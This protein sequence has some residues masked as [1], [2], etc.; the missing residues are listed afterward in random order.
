MSQYTKFPVNNSIQLYAS[1]AAFPASAANGALALA[2]DTDALYAYNTTLAAWVAIGGSGSVLSVGTI[3]SQAPSANGATININALIMQS[4]SGA[5]PGLVNLASQTFAGQKTFST[6]LTGTLTGSAS[7]NVLTSALG[8]L[9]DAGT[10]GIVVTG[11]TGSVVGSVSLAQHVADSTHNGYLSSTDWT[12]FNNKQSTLTLGN[13]TDAGTDGITVTGG[14]G[15]V[16]GAGTSLSQH[17]SDSTHNGYL[18]STDWTT[19]NNKQPAGSYITALTGDVT[20]TGPGSSAATVAKI[21]GTT[22]SGTTGTT[23][24]VF[25]ASPTLTGTITA[26]AANFSGAITAS[27]FSGSS[28]G[29]NT[30]DVTLTAFGS[31]PS[32]NGASLSGQA[33]TLQP[34]DATH[35][36]GVTTGSQTFAGTKTFTSTIAADIS[37][38]AA[39]ATSATTAT[40]ATNATNVATTATNATNASFFP[41]FV[42][43]SSSSNQGI[44]TATGLSFNP[45]TNTLTT[46]TFAG[47][48]TSA[49]T[50]TT[51]TTATNATNVATTSVSTNASFFPLFVA[52][53]TNSNQ[54][55]DLGTG[56]TFNP[57]TN[58][59]TTTT[60]TGALSGNA[61]TATTAT[62]ATNATN[63]ATT[64]VATNASF[65][66]LF[67]ASSS[68]GNQA[69]DLGTGLTF[70]PSTNTLSTTTFVGALTGT[71]SG[72]TTY[73]PNNHGVVLSSATNA[74]TVLAPNASTVFPLVSG[75]TG[76]DPSWAGLTVGGGGTGVTSN[77]AYAVLCGGTT[78][79]GAIQ[80]I[81]GVGT[82]GQV[83]TSNGAGALPTFQT[84]AALTNPMT[85]LGDIIYENAVP[86]PARLAGNTT[87]TKQ[88][89]SQ[90]GNGSI[91]ATPAWAQV[92]FA[93]ISGTVT[94][95]Q[96]GTG[97]SSAA[98]TGIAHV[99]AGTW[100]YSA[101]DLSGADATGTLAAGRFPALTGDITTSAGSLATTAAAT[102]ANI[103]TLSKSTGVAVHGTNTND[104]AAAGYVGEYVESKSSADNAYPA[105]ATWGDA[106]SI[107][108]TA[109][110]WDVSFMTGSIPSSSATFPWA[111][112]GISTTSGNSSTG[113][114]KGENL[115]FV[116]TNTISNT[117]Y[118]GCY[119]P[120]YRM[121]L[122]GT[123]T[124]YG[125]VEASWT[126][127]APSYA[128]RLS[129]RRVR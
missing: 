66:P 78:S 117:P 122:S 37:G 101:V 103:V 14:T 68:N 84:N 58:N 7:L 50:A 22:V 27:N 124:V 51:A 91:S 72:N 20:A 115:F 104:N 35:P 65:F 40:T 45:S 116:M 73:T 1:F 55:V 56:L 15:A 121:S 83:L 3:D 107:S 16:V 57:S 18:S 81:A 5:V 111:A 74:M 112:V 76:A 61:T 75:G 46:T 52:S 59:M 98:A 44:D 42:A 118:F 26:A 82:S 114:N 96:G 25:S 69:A 11:G 4:A 102:Q 109:G 28:S 85:T 43:S 87:T 34:A 30:G 9:T 64:S 63:V 53:S 120:V 38:N 106:T 13:L 97:G 32:A 23:N 12:T 36:G 126:V 19:F 113:L 119:V 99:A 86:A 128:Y 88:Y 24:V 127:S 90:T 17:V 67:V 94:A 62:T 110:D 54:A 2:L 93:D 6:G 70:N 100:S 41:T 108:L 129:A 47:N 77:T 80:S 125:K 8:N 123:T 21:Q 92:A 95:T 60:F 71:A 79:T 89:L 49:T 105:S 48:A 33:L 10:D 29:T 39:T 31:T